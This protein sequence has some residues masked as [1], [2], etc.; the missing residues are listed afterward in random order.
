MSHASRM[1]TG[2]NISDARPQDSKLTDSDAKSTSEPVTAD[3]GRAS[4]DKDAAAEMAAGYGTRSRNRT[5]NA[6]PNYAE[7][8]DYDVEMYDFDHGKNQ[9]DPKKGARQ[10]SGAANGETTARGSAGSRKSLPDDAI[11]AVSS[12]AGA[13]SKE[14]QQAQQ[15]QQSGGSSTGTSQA[16]TGSGG[17]L[18]SSRK[19]KA[20]VAAQQANAGTS[21]ST[22]RGGNGAAA[23]Q[24]PGSSWPESN[25]L[26]FSNSNARPQNGQLVADDGTV[27]EANGT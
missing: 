6:R 3:S 10:A 7:D 1:N 4:L 15:Q 18:H 17:G 24:N 12:Q 22:R 26:T 9:Q 21:V 5:G 8:K 23:G 16:M 19:R 11:K 14:Q 25:M 27:L 13:S 2:D 20:A